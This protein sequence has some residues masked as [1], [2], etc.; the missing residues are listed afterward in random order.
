MTENHESGH[1][2]IPGLELIREMR[3]EQIEKHGFNSEHD[4]QWKH[5]ELVMAAIYY[6][7]PDEV[8]VS[9][10][11][12]T[13]T[14]EPVSFFVKTGWNWELFEN[15][16]AKS[17]IECLAIAGALI[18]AEIDRLQRSLEMYEREAREV[19]DGDD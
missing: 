11:R 7:M 19:Y 18:A 8:D 14:L 6:A 4:D 17:T 1:G 12:Y 2:K 9:G 10:D 3:Q 5:A 13:V 15:R 16:H